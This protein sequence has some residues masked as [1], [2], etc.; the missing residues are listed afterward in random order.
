MSYE[1]TVWKSGDVVTS[2][3]LNK[4]ENGVA[5]GGGT[6]NIIVH[7]TQTDDGSHITETMDKTWKDIRDAFV[8]GKDIYI[9]DET[10]RKDITIISRYMVI[11]VSFGRYE[12]EMVYGVSITLLGSGNTVNYDANSE[13]DYPYL[14]SEK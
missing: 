13:N 6:E 7:L 11:S 4:L 12:G 8:A 14:V 1:P 10:I 9:I 3:K 2:A 5:G